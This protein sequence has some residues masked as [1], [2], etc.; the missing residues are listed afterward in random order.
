MRKVIAIFL[1]VTL[2]LSPVQGLAITSSASAQH[3]SE[4]IQ[5]PST[6]GTVEEIYHAP[7]S[8]L[9]PKIPRLMVHIKDAHANYEAQKNIHRILNILHDKYGFQLVTVEGAAEPLD[10]GYLE[11]FSDKERNQKVADYLLRKGEIS[12]TDLFLLDKTGMRPV[13]IE[14]IDD[15]AANL[16]FYRQVL[17]AKEE[18]DKLISYFESQLDLTMPRLLGK[19]LLK[20]VKLWEGF[21]IRRNELLNYVGAIGR[22]AVSSLGIDFS[23]LEAQIEWPSLWRILKLK[24]IEGKLDAKKIQEDHERLMRDLQTW[25][26]SNELSVEMG[27]LKV[28]ETSASSPQAS[29][30]Q[31]GMWPPR[32]V[33]ER[34][35]AEGA[36]HGFEFKN[37][38][39]EA[40]Y[41]QYLVLQSEIDPGQLFD[42]VN[43]L[44]DRLLA[45]FAKTDEEKQVISFIRDIRMFK[46]IYGLELLRADAASLKLNS[47]GWLPSKMAARLD[48][49]KEAANVANHKIDITPWLEKLDP[50]MK[51][52]L[53]FYDLAERRDGILMNNALSAMRNGGQPRAVMITGGYH[54]DGILEQCKQAGIS[55]IGISP[56]IRETDS[57]GRYVSIMMG[58]TDGIKVSYLAPNEVAQSG[59]VF[60][61]MDGADGN[62]AV[63]RRSLVFVDALTKAA[64]PLQPGDLHTVLR[65][66]VFR[67]DPGATLALAASL[68][69]DRLAGEI[70][71]FIN[72]IQTERPE[73]WF[74][75]LDQWISSETGTF[76]GGP[77][78]SEPLAYLTDRLLLAGQ[79]DAFYEL[80]DAAIRRVESEKEPVVVYSLGRLYQLRQG[81]L[82]YKKKSL[83]SVRQ[84]IIRTSEALGRDRLAALGTLR[85]IYDSPELI[86]DDQYLLPA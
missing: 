44:S 57:D 69:D 23:K 66:P 55:Y 50:L 5:I 1:S 22:E 61:L 75:A 38:P 43:R 30:D 82:R 37:Y 24:G 74:E 76:A 29:L 16:S 65:H 79:E 47:D 49:L 7:A 39:H 85:E 34:L 56:R 26:V 51:E 54:S 60:A 86:P 77:L 15:Y 36:A 17:G 33:F 67:E 31:N 45:V 52:V 73:Q 42:E 21:E 53:G 4:N 20:F 46:K 2:L 40:L 62:R 64:G 28:N 68:G 81:L 25:K 48:H 80:T 59:Q 70:A 27:K 83:E 13:G 84:I 35:A 58:Q 63:G 9:A 3:D 71:E 41:A 12:G 72:R 19:N 78:E 11:F 6:I 14:S 32:V 10:P 8:D 18:A